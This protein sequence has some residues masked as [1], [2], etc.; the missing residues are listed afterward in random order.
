ML[1]VMLPVKA[2]HWH[3]ILVQEQEA[4][5]TVDH[6]FSCRLLPVVDDPSEAGSHLIAHGNEPFTILGFGILNDILHTCHNNSIPSILLCDGKVGI[7]QQ[8]D[9]SGSF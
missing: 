9:G 3:F 8:S 6:R 1:E 2:D 5:V 7:P 4:G